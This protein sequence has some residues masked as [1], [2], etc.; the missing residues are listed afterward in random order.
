MR[1]LPAFMGLSAG[2]WNGNERSLLGCDLAGERLNHDLAILHDERVGAQPVHVVGSLRRPQD[3]A[4]I[5][6]D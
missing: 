3:V 5:A 2:L 6:L 1:R 4:I